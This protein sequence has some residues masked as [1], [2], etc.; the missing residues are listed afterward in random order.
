MLVTAACARR[1]RGFTLIEI[2]VTLLIVSSGLLG[3]A[4]LLNKSIVSNRHAYLVSQA[5]MLAYDLTERMR[6]NRAGALGGVY[7]LASRE[8][9]S[10]PDARDWVEALV[11]ALPDGDA[12]VSTAPSGDGLAVTITIKWVDGQRQ[13]FTTQTT[14]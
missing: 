13:S 7:T 8:A 6:A 1:Q 9:A 5:T 10:H 12:A 2:L 3:F 14:I 11:D 4:A